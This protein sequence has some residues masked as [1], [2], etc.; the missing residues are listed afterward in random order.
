VGSRPADGVVKH[1]GMTGYGQW[2]CK[3]PVGLIPALDVD[4]LSCCSAPGGK[5][6]CK[7]MTRVWMKEA[8]SQ[9]GSCSYNVQDISVALVAVP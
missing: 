6:L 1:G 5:F 2:R 9:S 4:E 8:R 7:R 3:S